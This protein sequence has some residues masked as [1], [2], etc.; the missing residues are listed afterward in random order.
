MRLVGPRLVLREFRVEDGADW[1]RVTGDEEVL[2]YLPW[3]RTT[4][5]EIAAGWLALHVRAAAEPER[6]EYFLAVTDRT[7]GE[8][9]GGAVLERE[10][11]PHRQAGSG[12]TAPGG[13]TVLV[14][15]PGGR[16]L[17]LSTRR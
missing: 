11:G 15:R 4:S 5:P 8:V 16:F 10:S 9:V 3:E 17:A 1:H 12:S 7:H 2:R 13:A 14:A 6:H